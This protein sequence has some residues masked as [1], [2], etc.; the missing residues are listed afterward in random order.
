MS[1]LIP[2]DR[3]HEGDHGKYGSDSQAHPSRGRAPG[4]VEADPGH[5]HDQAGGH[6]HLGRQLVDKTD[7]ISYSY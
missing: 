1:A 2:V 7:S 6:V 5:H 3:A 4:E